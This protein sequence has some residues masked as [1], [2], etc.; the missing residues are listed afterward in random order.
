[1]NVHMHGGTQF[2]TGKC[3][4]ILKVHFVEKAMNVY[5]LNLHMEPFLMFAAVKTNI[6][7]TCQPEIIYG[8]LMT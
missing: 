4:F 8:K 5:S 2:S 3:D 6:I 1:M 7:S